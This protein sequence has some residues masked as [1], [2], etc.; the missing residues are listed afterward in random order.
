MRARAHA[1][2]IIFIYTHATIK[3]LAKKR[4]QM[5]QSGVFARDVSNGRRSS[6]EVRY[7]IRT[8]TSLNL[9]GGALSVQ[10]MSLPHGEA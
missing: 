1:R 2:A 4:L 8:G 9:R 5:C 10:F 7:I 3:R 6:A